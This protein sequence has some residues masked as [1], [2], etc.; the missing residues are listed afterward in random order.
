MMK[1]FRLTVAYDGTNYSGWQAQMKHPS[2]QV[3]LEDAIKQ[4]TG[5]KVRVMSSGR[6]DAG[7]HALGQAVRLRVETRL[8][9]DELLRALNAVLP[10]DIAVR[11][12]RLAPDTFHPLRHVL[13]KRYRYW[14]HNGP[15]RDVLLRPYCWHYNKGLLDVEA[16]HR[17]AQALLG[18]H[19]FA[20]FETSGSKRKTSVRTIYD[21]SVRRMN[22]KETGQGGEQESASRIVPGPGMAKENGTG[23]GRAGGECDFLGD[24]ISA[25]ALKD[26]ISIEVEADGFLYNMVR[27][28]VGTLMEIGRGERPERWMTE[29]LEHKNRR[30]AGPNAP[31]QG[32]FLV[33]V[34][35]PDP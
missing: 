35:Y 4:I 12:V 30:R 32:L 22:T 10:P 24:F 14:I 16:M 7:V 17:A 2:V 19:D 21:I 11:E 18:K 8:E 34:R 26:W 13:T 27:S 25:S 20:S 29:V 31:P 9:P 5:K 1:T 28:I 6:T 33:R 23:Q 15:V 3:T